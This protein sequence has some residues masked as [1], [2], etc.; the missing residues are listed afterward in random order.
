M[1]YRI[2]P[3]VHIII[4]KFYHLVQAAQ[5]TPS[6]DVDHY[7][8]KNKK[9]TS[10]SCRMETNVIGDEGRHKVVAMIITLLESQSDWLV[11]SIGGILKSLRK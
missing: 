4:V 6:K 9:L 10:E 8:L 11:N 1:Q 7:T 2:K 5:F 3:Q